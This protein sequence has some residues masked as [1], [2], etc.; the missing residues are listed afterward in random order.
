MPLLKSRQSDTV[1]VG[2]FKVAPTDL[3]VQA[4]ALGERRAIP[5]GSP[6]GLWEA[7][8]AGVADAVRHLHPDERSYTFWK[9][10]RNSFERDAGLR[11][12]HVLLSPSA[13]LMLHSASVRREPRSWV[14]TSDHAP[15]MIELDLASG[16]AARM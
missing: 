3:D 13:A 7:R 8:R 10:W 9:Y 4:R 5:S 15:V 11:I 1:L 12:D 16:D 6:Q 2:D 14:H